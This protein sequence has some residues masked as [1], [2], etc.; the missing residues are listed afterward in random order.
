MVSLQLKEIAD[1]TGWFRQYWSSTILWW[2]NRSILCCYRQ[3]YLHNLGDKLFYLLELRSKSNGRVSWIRS[4]RV[5]DDK[6]I[7][8]GVKIRLRK[9]K[10]AYQQDYCD[11]KPTKHC[12]ELRNTCTSN[13]SDVAFTGRNLERGT[14]IPIALSKNWLK[15][16][17]ALELVFKE[18]E[19]NWVL[20][21]HMGRAVCIP[22]LLPQLQ[23][24]VEE[25][26]HHQLPVICKILS[27]T[28]H[29]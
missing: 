20:K 27:T 21:H 2:I 13:K 3:R 28:Q 14:L 19:Q 9:Q 25:L 4:G 16:P 18:N 22:E 29:S 17:K 23:F 26:S 5:A 7:N 6:A 1:F 12:D 24:Q 10:W 15:V 8:Q 11:T